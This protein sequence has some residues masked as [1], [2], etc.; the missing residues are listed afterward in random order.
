MKTTIFLLALSVGLN[1]KADF[2]GPYAVNPPTNGVY[3]EVG[4]EVAGPIIFGNWAC[5]IGAGWVTV[6]TSLAPQSVGLYEDGITGEPKAGYIQTS[7]AA[8]G[9]VSFNYQISGTN[10]G[11]FS[12]F[13]SN[14]TNITWIR[15]DVTN[16]VSTPTAASFPILAGQTFGFQVA[17]QGVFGA[18]P[19]VPGT[20]D[21]TIS[22]F[23][24]TAATVPPLSASMSITNRV[25]ISWLS[26]STG[27]ILQANTDLTTTNWTNVLIAPTDD[28]VTRSVSV[29]PAG[30]QFFRLSQ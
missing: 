6:D 21:V 15:T 24:V 26:P 18:L 23:S 28:G 13:Y 2:S 5:W 27:W 3:L 1:A 20:R 12:W 10:L 7:A 16:I 9:T 4:A 30:N 25:L 29:N 11:S 8:S 14:D 22:G 17:A 19:G